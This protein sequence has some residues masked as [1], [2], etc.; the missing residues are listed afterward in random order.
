MKVF[1]TGDTDE[2]PDEK[3]VDDFER[4]PGAI[5][6]EMVVG[7]M[8]YPWSLWASMALG[9]VLMLSPI[10]ITWDN[11]MAGVN[12]VVGALVLTFTVT[13]LAIAARAVRF[14]N[15][16]LGVVL[17]FAPFM[18]GASLWLMGF[19]FLMGAAL[20]A[21]SIPKGDVDQNY[22]DWNRLIV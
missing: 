5:M 10:V 4:G 15:A 8:T 11:G 1:F 9:V 21:L 20:I 7:G 3:I 13:A 16:L 12:H 18:T 14:M 22:D 6:A 19:S 17:M 2:G